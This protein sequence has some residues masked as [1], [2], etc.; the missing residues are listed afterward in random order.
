[1]RSPSKGVVVCVAGAIGLAALA[2]CPQQSGAAFPGRNGRIAFSRA[3]NGPETAPRVAI[4]TM[5]ASGTGSRRLTPPGQDNDSPSFS[6]G[7]RRIVYVR[8]SCRHVTPGCLERGDLW[9]MNADGSHKRR[10]TWTRRV[11]EEDPTWSPDGRHIAF[12]ALG[13][14]D[15]GIWVINSDGSHRR[16]LTHWGDEPS[17]SPDGRTIAYTAYEST[18]VISAAGGHPTHLIHG[19]AEAPDWSPDGTRIVISRVGGLWVMN[20]DGRD[21]HPIT[22]TPSL[23]D[24]NPVWSPDG[25]WIAYL[26]Y[27]V[28]ASIP[29]PQLY[30]IRPDGTGQHR[31]TRIGHPWFADGSADWQPR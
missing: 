4:W 17:W 30:L 22:N 6:A 27:P 8:Y 14:G 20:A 23:S 3:W 26:S 2:A 9:V 25:R 7:G 16:R 12:A 5:T 15:R 21:P 31:I 11:S 10:L 19:D 29:Y 1:M 13:G 28:K 24:L 18:Y